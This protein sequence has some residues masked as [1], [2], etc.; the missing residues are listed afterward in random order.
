MAKKTRP[1]RQRKRLHPPSPSRQAKVAN[2]PPYP[3]PEA[4]WALLPL[5]LLAAFVLR[6]AVALTGDFLLHPDEV[7]QYLEP[8]HRLVFGNGVAFW[9]Y[10]YGARSW[11]MPGLVAGVL[12]LCKLTGLDS[13]HAYIAVVKLFFCALSLMIPLGMY[14]FCRRHWSESS[15]RLALLF[16]VFWYELVAFAHKPMTEFAATALMCMLLAVMPLYA[17][18]RGWR[19][20]AAAGALG[21]LAVAFR[22]QYAPAIGV[23]LLFGFYHAHP[24]GRLAML[25]GGAAVLCAVAALETWNWGIPFYSYWLNMKF[26][27]AMEKTRLDEPL[28]L[29]LLL[30]ASGG[31]LAVAVLGLVGH[32]RRRG[33][34]FALLVLVMLPH[35]L[36]RHR[37][38]RYI[39]ATV[40]LWLILYADVVAV[41][42]KRFANA[43]A[44]IRRAGVGGVAVV[45][46]AGV[47]N[48][49]PHQNNI[50]RS[51]SNE[52]SHYSF[53]RNRDPSLQL[54]RRLSESDAVS[55]VLDASQIHATSGGYYYLHHKIPFYDRHVWR[56]I[57]DVDLSPEHYASHIITTTTPGGGS[58][59]NVRDTV[60]GQPAHALRTDYGY[61]LFPILIGDSDSGELVYWSTP[62]RRQPQPGYT[63]VEQA[64]DLILWHNRNAP[65]SMPWRDYVIYPFSEPRA[66]E[67]LQIRFGTRDIRRPPPN[68]GIDFKAGE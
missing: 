47:L 27:L 62:E 55:G 30:H 41:A 39:F 26:N 13:P 31:L 36:T 1:K 18:S 42:A 22:F 9:E 24:K 56:G 51:F 34:V 58:P 4:V 66:L 10:F 60:T 44:W 2:K 25:G 50:Y 61:E 3:Q 64:G 20:W 67:F 57:A 16:G 15:A 23:I 11:I 68:W 53:I 8:A 37:E 21:A 48:A 63:K 43:G 59:A 14:L 65:P 29:W 40:P 19:E 5:V 38:Y 49:I 6:A 7:M 12:Y 32:V 46:V 35:L 52:S 45:S 17:P 54:Y 33:F 28:Q